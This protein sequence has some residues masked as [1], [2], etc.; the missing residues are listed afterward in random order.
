M[1][2]PAALKETA[3]LAAFIDG[4]RNEIV[5]EWIKFAAT[6]L[7]AAVGMDAA[8]LR[9]HADQILT[10]IVEDMRSH[11]TVIEQSEKSKGHGPAQELSEIGEVHAALRIENGFKLGQMVA[12]Y[13][14]LRASV[15]RWWEKDG[16]DPEGITRFNEAI[17]EALTKAVESFMTTSEQY[18]D[19]SLGILGHDL[20]NPLASI[21][22]GA[23]SLLV[24]EP[25]HSAAARVARRMLTT[26]HGMNRM[27]GDLLDLTRTRF[28]DTIPVVR[29]PLDLGPICRQVISELE[30]TCGDGQLTFTAMGDLRGD[31]DGDRIAQVLANLV[32]NAIQHGDPNEKI[33]IVGEEKGKDVV[34]RVH[35]RGAPIPRTA[36]A[37]IFEPMVRNVDAQTKTGFGLGLYI[38]EQIV[39]AHGGTLVATST[40]EA[41][42]TFTARLPRHAPHD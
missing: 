21:I 28:G 10:A 8:A 42:T 18:R 27:I 33:S 1:A 2:N 19:Q 40:E 35:N 29:T 4:H 36:M 12:E 3:G 25:T 5:N 32:R 31:W 30:G 11:Q 7:P 9:D 41:G 6:L 13:R 20:R 24:T 22:V 17:D 34:V 26:A 23:E 14:A 16:S 15:L 38:A 39:L 37:S